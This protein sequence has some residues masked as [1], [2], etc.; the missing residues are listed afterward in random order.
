[1]S[2]WVW[3]WLNLVGLVERVVAVV[4]VELG[5]LLQAIQLLQQIQ[6]SYLPHR[7]MEQPVVKGFFEGLA[8]VLVVVE[9]VLYT[10]GEQRV[11]E[12]DLL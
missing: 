4:L 3:V 12:S 8:P 6:L 5:K 9:Q 7:H 11:A 1:M 2:F 10:L